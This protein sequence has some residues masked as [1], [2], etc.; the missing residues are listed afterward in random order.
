MLAFFEN[1]LN[2]DGVKYL[3]RCVPLSQMQIKTL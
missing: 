1:C 2:I 3:L